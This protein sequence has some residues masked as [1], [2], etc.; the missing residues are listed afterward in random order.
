MGDLAE[1]ITGGRTDQ[2][3]EAGPA[4]PLLVGL[5]DFCRQRLVGLLPALIV[6]LLCTQ[7]GAL[8][9]MVDQ[10]PAQLGQ[11]VFQGFGRGV[12]GHLCGVL[13]QALLTFLQQHAALL[14][15]FFRGLQT[16]AQFIDLRV[17]HGQQAIEAGIV[18][19]R[20]LAA[21]LGDLG[22]QLLAFGIQ[23]LLLL[24]IGLELAGQLHAL[25]AQI[26]QALGGV[27]IEGA[28]LFQRGFHM[29]LP[30]FGTGMFA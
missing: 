20:M 29:L 8:L 10:P 27:G 2:G 13:L 28:G 26:L 5:F 11:G 16:L 30:G 18:Q 3:I 17:I 23:C 14:D 15:G 24:G 12:H 25:G 21:P 6:G 1:H 9:L 22:L 7:F 19:F 4:L